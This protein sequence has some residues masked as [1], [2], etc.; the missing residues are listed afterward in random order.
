MFESYEDVYHYMK[1]VIPQL[2]PPTSPQ[3][4]AWNS[5]LQRLSELKAMQ[6]W[7]SHASSDSSVEIAPNT[8]LAR[9]AGFGVSSAYITEPGEETV[10]RHDF[11]WVPVFWKYLGLKIMNAWSSYPALK[12]AMRIMDGPSFCY[13]MDDARKKMTDA[14]T[15]YITI[16]VEDACL[17]YSLDTRSP[18]AYSIVSLL[19]VKNRNLGVL[20][21]E[22]KIHVAPELVDPTLEDVFLSEGMNHKDAVYFVGEYPYETA[23]GKGFTGALESPLATI[24]EGNPR[25]YIILYPTSKRKNLHLPVSGLTFEGKKKNPNYIRVF[26]ASL[27][28]AIM[29]LALLLH[30]LGRPFVIKRLDGLIYTNDGQEP[31]SLKDLVWKDK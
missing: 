11:T 2:M 1:K 30:R 23:L 10:T 31:I 12:Y 17:L 13:G 18:K 29:H 26:G 19:D 5:Y 25:Q 20:G 28:S 15:L 16:G 4:E 9:E 3:G 14:R 8:W 22:E 7:Y 27:T 21:L 6:A 24:P